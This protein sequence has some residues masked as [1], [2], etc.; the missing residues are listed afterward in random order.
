MRQAARRR[1]RIT[2]AALLPVAAVATTLALGASGSAASV[3]M[4]S[5]FNPA[6]F[7]KD[8]ALATT[9]L[10][11]FPTLPASP[12]IAKNKYIINISG[13][14]SAS[15]N[16]IV[17]KNIIAASKALGWRELTIDTMSDPAKI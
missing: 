1:G 12:P 2:L 14:L 4:K 5:T 17:N 7:K 8:L 10:T 15:G 11:K 6:P 13:A 16:A 9:T 3:A